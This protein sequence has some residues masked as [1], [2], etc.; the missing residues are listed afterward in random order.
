MLNDSLIIREMFCPTPSHFKRRIQTFPELIDLKT[1]NLSSICIE[2]KSIETNKSIIIN[3]F[4]KSKK[5]PFILKKLFFFKSYFNELGIKKKFASSFNFFLIEATLDQQKHVKQLTND[6]NEKEI[7][8]KQKIDQKINKKRKLEKKQDKNENTNTN[9]Y[10]VVF[11]DIEEWKN[12]YTNKISMIETENK[13]VEE[14]Y[15]SLL[16]KKDNE[17]IEMK[18]KQQKIQENF[19]IILKE[20]SLYK[21]MCQELLK[22]K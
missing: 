14:K 6:Q 17:I 1:E 21:T 8:F 4:D 13:K 22:K 9:N 7:Y 2:I 10:N 15:I 3:I 19:N 18:K 20:V 5:N 11:D 16:K 12:S